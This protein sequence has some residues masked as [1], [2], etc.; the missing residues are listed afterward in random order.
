MLSFANESMYLG[1]VTKV[2][3]YTRLVSRGK[4]KQ[5]FYGF[6]MARMLKGLL[7]ELLFAD[8]VVEIPTYVRNDN[9]TLVRQVDSANAVTRGERLNGFLES[10]REELERNNWLS[11]GYIPGG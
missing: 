9:A 4:Y 11:I 2:L 8:T 1:L 10:N 7:A 5:R 3:E 6:D